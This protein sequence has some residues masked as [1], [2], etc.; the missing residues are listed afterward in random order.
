MI[1]Q[2]SVIGLLSCLGMSFLLD[3]K[4]VLAQFDE[5]A[6]G[7]SNTQTAPNPVEADVPQAGLPPAI[8]RGFTDLRNGTFKHNE[9][10]LIWLADPTWI[11]Q[12]TSLE[13]ANALVANVQSG[14]HGLT[15]GSTAGMWRLPSAAEWDT[16]L[17]PENSGLNPIFWRGWPQRDAAGRPVMSS[18]GFIG[19][20]SPGDRWNG[21]YNLTTWG[22]GGRDELF[23]GSGSYVWPVR[24]G[25]RETPVP[26]DPTLKDGR[27]SYDVNAGRIV[28]ALSRVMAEERAGVHSF[29]KQI[30][31]GDPRLV[32]SLSISVHDDDNS[33]ELQLTTPGL[34]SLNRGGAS[35]RVEI[36]N[37]CTDWSIHYPEQVIFAQG[38][39]LQSA[40]QDLQTKMNGSQGIIS[41][42][43][44]GDA[45]QRQAV[46]VIQSR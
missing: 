12:A 22:D 38:H 18:R 17:D 10:A 29:F 11:P 31:L 46:V 37:N 32:L 9:T 26:R 3:T 43:G 24:A 44:T 23:F 42:S 6:G 40:L 45:L 39:D 16:A 34:K 4:A 15:D 21:R 25:S 33:Y 2:I 19:L 5:A 7:I 13:H 41:V 28:L 35:N 1:R 36:F 8:N 14:Q 30:E 20:A 27:D